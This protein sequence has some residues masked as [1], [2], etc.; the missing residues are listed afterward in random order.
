MGW[1]VCELSRNQESRNKLREEVDSTLNRDKM[2]DT[3]FL[4]QMPSCNKRNTVFI[5]SFNYDKSCHN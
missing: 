2:I 3:E 5:S 1:I 4:E